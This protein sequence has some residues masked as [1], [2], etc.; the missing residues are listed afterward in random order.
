MTSLEPFFF[1]TVNESPFKNAAVLIA[2]DLDLIGA[3]Y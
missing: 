2:K 3:A 1:K